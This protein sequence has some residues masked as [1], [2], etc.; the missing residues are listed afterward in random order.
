M[1]YLQVVNNDNLEQKH[2]CC[3]ISNHKDVQV[4]PKKR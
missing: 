3:A 1:E 4:L 2:I